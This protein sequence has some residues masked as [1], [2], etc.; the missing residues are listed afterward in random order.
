MDNWRRMLKKISYD[1][2]MDDYKNILIMYIIIFVILAILL[3]VSIILIIYVHNQNII[4]G[5]E[6]LHMNINLDNFPRP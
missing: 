1:T 2:K 4:S 5:Y 3:L 6:L